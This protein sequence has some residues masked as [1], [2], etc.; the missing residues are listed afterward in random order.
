MESRQLRWERCLEQRLWHWEARNCRPHG[1]L[2]SSVCNQVQFPASAPP[3]PRGRLVYDLGL[4]F[5]YSRAPGIG[6]FSR[7]SSDSSC[8]IYSKLLPCVPDS[9]LP[10]SSCPPIFTFTGKLFPTRP[11]LPE[12]C[13]HHPLDE[14]Y[15]PSEVSG[16]HTT[17]KTEK[18]V[19]WA[20]S[21][22]GPTR[23][24]QKPP[25]HLHEALLPSREGSVPLCPV[26]SMWLLEWVEIHKNVVRIWRLMVPEVYL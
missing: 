24:W 26:L 25:L 14:G 21:L 2:R 22:P 23:N 6:T 1:T 17:P 19:K 18:R 12:F 7:F 9:N 3:W 10:W 11:T 16:P 4:Q 13:C 15:K 8:H 5:P 20:Q